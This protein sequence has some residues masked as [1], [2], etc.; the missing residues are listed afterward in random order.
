[1]SESYEVLSRK[2]PV[3]LR[4]APTG[5]SFP[6]VE[7]QVQNGEEAQEVQIFFILARMAA[8]LLIAA[9]VIAYFIVTF[10]V[11]ELKALWPRGRISHPE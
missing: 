4:D 11:E 10:G 5:T 9:L 6:A 8:I 2:H 1:M 7:A 3:D